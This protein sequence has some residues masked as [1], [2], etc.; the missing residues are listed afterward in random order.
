LP[1]ALITK[2]RDGGGVA[3]SFREAGGGV[4]GRSLARWRLVFTC[5]NL[6][7]LQPRGLTLVSGAYILSP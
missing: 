5:E 2:P 3:E 6:M 1:A 7:D 4:H